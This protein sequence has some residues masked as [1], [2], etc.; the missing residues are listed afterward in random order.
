MWRDGEIE[1]HVSFLALHE[2]LVIEAAIAGS[3]SLSDVVEYVK[4]RL[5]DGDV[6]YVEALYNLMHREEVIHAA[7]VT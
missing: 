4:S 1:A 6:R 7:D 5:P 2:T 3:R